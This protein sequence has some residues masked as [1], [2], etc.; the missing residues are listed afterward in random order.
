MKRKVA[1][2]GTENSHALAFAKLLQEKKY[3]DLDLVGIYGYDENANREILDVK[4]GIECAERP[5][6]FLG[7]VDA[8]II[9]ARHGTHH[10]EYGMPYVKAGVPAFI[11]KPFTV[12]MN[13]A[14]ALAAAAEAAGTPLCGGSCL[15]FAKELVPLREMLDDP[16]EDLGGVTGAWF[17]APIDLHNP[18]GGFFF[19]TQHLVQMVLRVFG[20]GIRSVRA[21]RVGDA[22]TALFRYPGFDVTGLYGTEGY[23]AAIAFRRKTVFAEIRDVVG[24]YDAELSEFS[25]MLETGIMPETYEDLIRPVAVLQALNA[26]MIT[27]NEIEVRL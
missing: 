22:V 24:F 18:Y 25:E 3:E 21:A 15:K 8:V 26:A 10:Y 27:G 2:L 12:E 19:Y 16:T 6:A 17:T 13:H 4:P 14:R 9:T 11:D 5:D 23:S 1:I 20:G 7:R